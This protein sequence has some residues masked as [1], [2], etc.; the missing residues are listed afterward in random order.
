MCLNIYDVRFE[1]LRPACG[2]NWPPDIHNI[3]I[4]L[5]RPEVVQ[6]MHA[7]RKSEAWIECRRPLHAA[8]DESRS[9]SS[10]TLIPKLLQRVPILIFAGDQDLI[11]NYMGLEAMIQSLT[12][13]GVTGFGTVETQSWSVNNTPAGTWVSNRN[14]TYAKLFNASHMAP[15]DVPHVTH[16]MILRFMG[17]NF[18]AITDGSARIPSSVG[19]DSKPLFVE[20]SHP[21]PTLTPVP[22]KTPQQDHAMWEAYYNAGSAAL[23]LVLIVV[24]IG[25]FVW[26]RIR[27]RRKL[28]P[29]LEAEESIPLTTSMG[30]GQRD[31]EESFRQRKGKERAVEATKPPIFD[32]GD[33]D[34]DD[35]NFKSNDP[36]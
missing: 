28:I 14:L 18:S 13:G 31:D 10:I 15:F 12:W 6:A 33:D 21:R 8:F 29:L 24:A 26:C 5:D 23:V 20:S 32:V 3:T 11:C 19:T 34:D 17:A 7:E 35:D 30:D 2:L 25:T 4:Y 36:R 22:G 16:D 1:D 9:N 27:R